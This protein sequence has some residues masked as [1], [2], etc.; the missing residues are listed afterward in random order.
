L[1]AQFGYV[2]VTAMALLV[3]FC[4]YRDRQRWAWAS[5]QGDR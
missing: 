2:V 5:T 4:P 1:R 3:L